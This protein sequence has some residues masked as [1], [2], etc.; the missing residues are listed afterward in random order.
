M[1]I[2]V[3]PSSSEFKTKDIH[4]LESWTAL[5]KFLLDYHSDIRRLKIYQ[6][7]EFKLQ[8]DLR[9]KDA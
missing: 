6:A 2:V 7:T 3:A 8:L 1:Y 4:E 5:E 9:K